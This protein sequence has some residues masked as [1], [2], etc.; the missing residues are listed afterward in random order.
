M[1]RAA[2]S[3]A[4]PRRA[5]VGTQLRERRRS[6]GVAQSA[7]AARV[8]ISASYLNLIEA[9]KRNIGGALLKRLAGELGLAIDEIDGAR[10]RRLVADLAQ[11]AGEPVLAEYRID[12]ASAAEFAGVHASWASALVGL[13][14][15]WIDRDQ[16]VAALSDRLSHDPFLGT[17]VH[18]M[19]SRLAAIRSSTEILEMIDDLEPE[20]RR[21]FASIAAS[22]SARLSDVAQALAAYFDKAHTET[23]SVTPV[24]EVD[25]FLFDHDNHFP[26]LEQAAADFRTT[27]GIRGEA[28][29][30]VLVDYLRRTHSVEVSVRPAGTLGP[31]A[32]RRHV[33]FDAESRTLAISDTAPRPTRRFEIARLA[34]ELFHQGR[35]AAALVDESTLLTSEAAR[36]RARGALG[37]YLA[38]A[39]LMPYDAFLEAA[40]AARYDFD[41]LV[42]HFGVSF[43]Q[44]CHRLVT[45]RRPGAA[46]I[47]FG[48]MRVDPA[49]YVTKRMPLAL[50]PLPRH[51][52]ACPLWA[53]YQAFQTPG[54]FVR[55]LAA[56]P[57]GE[58]FLFLART[59]EKQRPA[60]GLPRRF[61]SVMLACDALYAEQTIYGDGLDLGAPSLAVP[62][63]ANCRVCTRRDCA[64]REEDAIIDA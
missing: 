51:G 21:R 37:A 43:E 23:R 31:G 11:L 33:V 35:S 53:V 42:Q 25:D 20:Q 40:L 24:E 5:L 59:V 19:L 48:F 34:T 7:L 64:Y 13:H 10:Q 47:R 29:E 14:R 60:F 45:L 12:P 49:G 54:V 61:V 4:S 41:Y 26:T 3:P 55:Q 58:R 46:G 22:E 2:M 15:A 62:V 63:G 36:R 50:L 9:N 6:L 18:S 8:G 44:V 1:T 16:A 52:N 56:F 30:T 28:D 17:A 38:G 32:A 27:A 39:V 57:S